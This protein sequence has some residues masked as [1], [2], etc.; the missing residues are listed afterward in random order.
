MILKKLNP[1]E[2]F[3]NL[4]D[5]LEDLSLFKR[6][7]EIVLELQKE[8]KLEEIGFSVDPN[9]NLYVGINLNPELLLY[10]ET[11]TEAVELKMVAEKTKRYTDFLTKEGILDSIRV[12]Y[13]RVKTETYYGYVLQ[14]S[15]NFKKYKRKDLIYDICYFA[16]AGLLVASAVL[17][18]L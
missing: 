13:D 7:K 17:L 1:V 10:S 18:I 9:S 12:E 3:R 5:N 4:Q 11:S 2:V 15:Y 14:V 8:G 16:V 6:Y